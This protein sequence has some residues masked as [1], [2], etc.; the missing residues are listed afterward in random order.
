MSPTACSPPECVLMTMSVALIA[1]RE[2]THG[3]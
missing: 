1:A 3:P 2:V